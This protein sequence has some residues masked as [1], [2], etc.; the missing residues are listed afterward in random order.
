LAKE[1]PSSEALLAKEDPSSEALLAK[2]EALLVTA[3]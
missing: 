3:N 1:D 2:E